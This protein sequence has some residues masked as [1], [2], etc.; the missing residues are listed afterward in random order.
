[1]AFLY[2]AP[3][4]MVGLEQ[5]GGGPAATTYNINWITDGVPGRPVNAGSGT[6]L[7]T[8]TGAI[9]KPITLVALINSNVDIGA[10]VGTTIGPTPPVLS[11]GRVPYNP[12]T[13]NPAGASGTVVTVSVTA[14]TTNIVAGMIAGGTARTLERPIMPGARRDWSTFNR[15]PDPQMGNIAVYR[16]D[17]YAR[18]FSG[19]TT[20]TQD[21]LDALMAWYDSTNDGELPSLIVPDPDRN[22]CWCVKF[23]AFGW[24]KQ[25]P[26]LFEVTLT[27]V[28]YPRRKW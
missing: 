8:A 24:Q 5:T 17:K 20:M 19:S 23:G 11:A 10:I 3:G 4:D 28:E 13:Y 21:G 25:S 22:D 1:M 15:Q 9:A 18:S 26:T 6:A 12:F 7:W 14:N 2:L 27:F 16:T